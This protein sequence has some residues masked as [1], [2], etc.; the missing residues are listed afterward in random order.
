MKELQEWYDNQA[1]WCYCGNPTSAVE[2]VKAGL[3]LADSWAKPT[4]YYKRWE[5]LCVERLGS[6]GVQNMLWYMFDAWG[7]TEHGG[8]VPGWLTAKGKRV[9]ELL[10]E[11]GCDPHEW[12]GE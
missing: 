1:Q 6:V 3:E 2:L 10:N 7:W 11:H 12:Q 5:A 9:L 8:C 4:N